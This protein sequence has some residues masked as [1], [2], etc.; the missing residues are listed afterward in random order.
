MTDQQP[1]S[2][3][4][5]GEPV[6]DTEGTQIGTVA[7]VD[8]NTA[9]VDPEPELDDV[10]ARGSIG[11]D[12]PT[13]THPVDAADL[14]RVESSDGTTFRVDLGAVNNPEGADTHSEHSSQ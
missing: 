7:G 2:E 14:D 11:W 4:D 8:G 3:D 1:L 10:P 12:D 13:E 9:L 5:V 6:V